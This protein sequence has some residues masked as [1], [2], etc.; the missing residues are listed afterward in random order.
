MVI[1]KCVIY[2][3]GNVG[4]AEDNTLAEVKPVS[5]FTV[6]KLYITNNDAFFR[7]PKN[8]I[9][10]KLKIMLHSYEIK[11]FTNYFFHLDSFLLTA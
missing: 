2:R 3:N 1:I 8:I 6:M 9:L 5:F 7:K 11:C 4:L 10:I